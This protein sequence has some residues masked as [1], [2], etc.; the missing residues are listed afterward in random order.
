MRTL[1]HQPV[2]L[3]IRTDLTRKSHLLQKSA[4]CADDSDAV[5][6]NANP[7]PPLLT[8]LPH[9]QALDDLEAGDP[10]GQIGEVIVK[11]NSYLANEM[12]LRQELPGQ[13]RRDSHVRHRRRTSAH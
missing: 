11:N 7:V 12:F 13:A 10:R 5:I 1:N 8:D 9:Q 4:F 2:C 6:G 3:L